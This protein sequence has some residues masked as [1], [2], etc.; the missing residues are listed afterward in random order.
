MAGDSLLLEKLPGRADFRGELS[1]GLV[2]AGVAIPLAMGYGM[3]AFVALGDAYFPD[4]ALAGLITAAALGIACVVLGDK[5]ANIYAPRVTT[6]FFIGILLYGL[7]HSNAAVLKSGGLALTVAAMFSIILLAGA[8]QALFGLTRLGTM[9]RFIPQPVMSGFQNAAALL[10][11]LIQLGNVFGFSRST[12]FVQ[13]L[14]DVQHARPLSVLIA[15]LT[16][17]AMVLAAR[18]LP[19]IPALLVGLGVGTVL[20]YALGI[21]GL[22]LHLGPTIGSVPFAAFKI[23]GLPHFAE[24]AQAPGAA[25]LVPTIIGGALALAIVASIDALLCTKILSRPGDAKIDGDRLLVRLGVGERRGRRIRRDHRRPEY[26]AEPRQQGVRRAHAGVD[27]GQRG[28][29]AADGR[30]ALPGA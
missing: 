15:A 20:Y 19:K 18:R 7:V 4:G 13:A 3:F 8:F 27:A 16:M 17:V 14:Q 9:I 26:R 29:A 21:A 28:G 30:G 2:S 22:G 5:S 6:T 1:G 12:P 11:L 23:P 25:A 10:L 24:L